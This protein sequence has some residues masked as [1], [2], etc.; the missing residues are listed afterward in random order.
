[1][2][3]TYHTTTVQEYLEW[4]PANY[5]NP[6]NRTWLAPYSIVLLFVGTLCTFG[7][8]WIRSRNRWPPWDDYFL[9]LAWVGSCCVSSSCGGYGGSWV[10][11]VVVAAGMVTA[12][13]QGIGFPCAW[14]IVRSPR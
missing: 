3:G 6:E 5:T 2:P 8:L 7:R 1:M 9:F 14:P 4:P 10:A 13:V 11:V 12:V